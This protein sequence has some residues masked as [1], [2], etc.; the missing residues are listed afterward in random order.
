MFSKTYQAIKKME[1]SKNK[2]AGYTGKNAKDPKTWVNFKNTDKEEL[3]C[4]NLSV[5]ERLKRFTAYNVF[6]VWPNFC[7]YALLI[8]RFNFSRVHLAV[9]KYKMYIPFD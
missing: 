6:R 1:K 5:W 9:S 7:Y 2:W 4:F 8:L 3:F